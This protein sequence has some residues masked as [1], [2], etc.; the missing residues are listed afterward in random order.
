MQISYSNLSQDLSARAVDQ[1]VGQLV[2]TKANPM[3]Q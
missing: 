1:H 3:K 2:R